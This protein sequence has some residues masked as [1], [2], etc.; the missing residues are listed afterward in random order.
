MTDKASKPAILSKTLRFLAAG[1]LTMA[2]G[3]VQ[4]AVKPDADWALIA[5]MA[6]G[7]TVAVGGGGYGRIVAQGPV[8]SL[9]GR[10]TGR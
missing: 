5:T 3:M 7:M 6:A 1:G 8:T 9:T 2:F 4:E 10:S